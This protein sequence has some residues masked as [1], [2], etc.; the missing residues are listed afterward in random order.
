MAILSKNREEDLT[1]ITSQP[2]DLQNMDLP[3]KCDDDSTTVSEILQ[4]EKDWILIK[5]DETYD[6]NHKALFSSSSE[7]NSG[8]S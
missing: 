6:R 1:M 5:S 3:S 8:T 2:W 4:F 7:I